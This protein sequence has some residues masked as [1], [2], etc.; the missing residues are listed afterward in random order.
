MVLLAPPAWGGCP[1]DALAWAKQCSETTGVV[2]ERAECPDGVVVLSLRGERGTPLS[3]E[4]HAAGEGSFRTVGKLGLSPVGRFDDWLTEP[5]DERTAFDR[6]SGC[7]AR[8]PGPLRASVERTRT[9][10]GTPGGDS[11][12]REGRDTPPVLPW[13]LA[14]AAVFAATACLLRVRASSAVRRARARRMA[15]GLAGLAFGTWCARRL[16]WSS[17]FFHQNGQGPLWIRYALGRMAPFTAY[18]TGYREIFSTP[19]AAFGGDPS[20]SV[21]ETQ[22]VLGTVVPACAWTIARRVGARRPVAALL[23][24]LVA[25]D[26]LLARLAESESY[27]ATTLALLISA[28]ALLCAG[29][30]LERSHRWTRWCAVLGAGLLVAQAARVHIFG[31]VPAAMVPFPLLLM[32]GPL[33]RRA[34]FFAM[35]TLGIAVVV[36]IGAAPEMRTVLVGPLGERFGT[37]RR[38]L[39]D[40]ALIPLVLALGVVLLSLRATRSHRGV[41]AALVFA[42]SIALGKLMS[43]IGGSPTPWVDGAQRALFAPALIAS[44]SAWSSMLSRTKHRALF[45]ALALSLSGAFLLTRARSMTPLPTDALEASWVTSFKA[46]LPAGATVSYLGRVGDRI[47]ELPLYNPLP[48]SAAEPTAVP[49]RDAVTLLASGSDAYYVRTTLCFTPEGA[50]V[51]AALERTAVLEPVQSRSLPARPSM[52]DFSYLGETVP[53]GLFRVRGHR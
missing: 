49:L 2:V 26:P 21:F 31:W 48:W 28:S 12:R 41:L 20:R 37:H 36:L 17:A 8:D 50:P 53:V 23:A 30:P 34:R 47:D 9:A 45:A 32:R 3:V 51:C 1:P 35:A 10:A 6:L 46:S 16:F 18:G 13:R 7:A 27:F 39:P 4:V 24:L 19:V 29:V 44:A 15:L 14:L 52:R 33:P 42:L 25:C 11:S 38:S 5:E 22:A 43:D 40:P